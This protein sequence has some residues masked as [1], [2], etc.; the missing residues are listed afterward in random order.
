M[1]TA[2]TLALGMSTN[3]R[4]SPSPSKAPPVQGDKVQCLMQV[5]ILALL[6]LKEGLSDP[7]V[8]PIMLHKP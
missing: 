4:F 8:A 5:L 2:T 7:H 6:A 3:Q 1:S